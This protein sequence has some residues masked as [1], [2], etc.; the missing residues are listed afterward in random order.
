[1]SA[2]EKLRGK[3]L[4]DKEIALAAYDGRDRIVSSHELAEE[5][6]KTDDSIFKIPTGVESLE[7]IS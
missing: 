3:K 2:K 5:L 4:L 7:R 6:K 1:M